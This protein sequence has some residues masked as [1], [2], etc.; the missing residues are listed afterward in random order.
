MDS[1]R[2]ITYIGRRRK[3]KEE[4]ERAGG[5]A[6]EDQPDFKIARIYGNGGQTGG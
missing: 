6:R 3:A 5:D 4:G 2:R 1:S